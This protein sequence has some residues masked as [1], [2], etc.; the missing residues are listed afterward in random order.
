MTSASSIRGARLVLRGQRTSGDR[1]G[2]TVPDAADRVPVWDQI[3]SATGRGSQFQSGLQV[4]LRFGLDGESAERVHDQPE[5]QLEIPGQQYL[6][7][8]IQRDTPAVYG[9]GTGRQSD[10]I[11]KN[12]LKGTFVNDK[13]PTFD[14]FS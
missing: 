14:L 4:V 9:E 1:S 6:G 5:P 13:F 10:S 2:G 11:L 8:D 3:G 7:T 12:R